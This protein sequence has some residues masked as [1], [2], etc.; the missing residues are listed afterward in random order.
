MLI[1][2]LLLDHS[3]DLAQR[4]STLKPKSYVAATQLADTGL[5]NTISLRMRS[6][7]TLA[8]LIDEHAVIHVC[9][10]PASGKSTMAKLL[11]QQYS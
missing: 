9:G 8:C 5:F 3:F 4:L 10:T 1:C 6:I 7:E 11:F 2:S